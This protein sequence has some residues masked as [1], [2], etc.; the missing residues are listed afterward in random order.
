MKLKNFLPLL[1]LTFLFNACIESTVTRP[2]TSANTIHP[3]FSEDRE[4]LKGK[5][6][7]VIPAEEILIGSGNTQTSG[8][9]TF[10]FLTVDIVSPGSFPSS[11]FAFSE[12]ANEI[13]DIVKQEIK[14]IDDFQKM[15]IE[16]R[17]TV[18]ENNTEHSRTYKKEIDL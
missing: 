1:L 15:K 4:D 7:A 6:S 5:I 11:G 2:A 17:N 14:N 12:Q 10:H 8:E 16:V 3:E 9:E 18:E 13:R